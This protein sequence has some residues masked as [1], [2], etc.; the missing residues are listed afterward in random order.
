MTTV[1]VALVVMS[2]AGVI[3]GVVL[4]EKEFLRKIR[5]FSKVHGVVALF[6]EARKRGLNNALS[7]AGV[8]FVI[9]TVSLSSELLFGTWSEIASNNE[10]GSLQSQN[11]QLELQIAPRRLSVERSAEIAAALTPSF[12]GKGVRLESYSLDLES[13]VLGKQIADALTLA[14]ID[15]DVALSRRASADPILFGVHVAGNNGALKDALA[16]ALFKAGIHTEE[17]TSAPA[18]VETRAEFNAKPPM[19]KPDAIVFIG[20]KPLPR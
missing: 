15:V 19:F 9:L 6:S 2:N 11:L 7:T 8:G 20:V 12:E 18:D 4:E 5:E 13:Q 16:D 10:L 3:F 14:H 17:D 1:L